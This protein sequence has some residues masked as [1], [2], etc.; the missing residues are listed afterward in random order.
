MQRGGRKR[1]GEGPRHPALPSA[2]GEGIAIQN[3]DIQDERPEK[4]PASGLE[5]HWNT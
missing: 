5:V 4:H 1:Q 2:M 3:K